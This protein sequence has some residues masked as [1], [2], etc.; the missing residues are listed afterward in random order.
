M[1][2]VSG[3]FGCAVALQ[4]GIEQRGQP[5]DGNGREP[6]LLFWKQPSAP[7]AA[8]GPSVVSEPLVSCRHSL[9]TRT[10][11]QPLPVPC[12]LGKQLQHK[13]QSDREQQSKGF[14]SCEAA[15]A[16]PKAN[17]GFLAQYC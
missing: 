3:P 2:P 15:S 14:P 12:F 10:A 13:Q 17:P 5:E 11:A 8:S 9:G 4:F 1:N 16:K 6:F 7:A